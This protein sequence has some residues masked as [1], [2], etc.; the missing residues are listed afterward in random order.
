M[1]GYSHFNVKVQ[2]IYQPIV[3]NAFV[4]IACEIEMQ[5]EN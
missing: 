4:K 1:F 5:N 2:K 3:W